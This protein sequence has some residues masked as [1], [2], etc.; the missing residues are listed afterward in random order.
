MTL[1]VGIPACS[2][3][4]GIEPA[5]ST[6]ERYVSALMGVTGAVPVLLP[7]VGSAM[8]AALDRL[9]GVLINGS[10]SNVHPALYGTIESLTPD[11]HD[12]A[13][14]DTTIPLIRAALDRGVPML[15]IC[16]GIQELNV[17][18]G[19]TLHQQVHTLPGR[20]DHRSGGP[21]ELDHLFRLKHRVRVSGQLAQIVG[22]SEITVN[23]L[24]EQAID[25]VAD[26][27][28]VEAVADDGTI[29]GVRALGARSFAFGVQY[30]PEWHWRT[31]APSIALFR[32]FGAACA[33][34]ATGLEKAA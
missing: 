24:H 7:P 12:A 4:V 13:R 26:G 23:S 1:L 10:R 31:D 21:G 9:D 3:T 5:F 8:I 17:A 2:K 16:R 14:D 15:C 30:H 25:R 32:A 33:T 11:K 6:P 27:L 20:D 19:G 22:A 34:Y 28:A 29:E 18:L